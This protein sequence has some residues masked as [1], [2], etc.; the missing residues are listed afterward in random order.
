MTT[1]PIFPTLPGQ[2]WSVTRTKIT[3]TRIAAHVSGREVRSANYA[4]ALH[5]FELTFNG[6]DSESLYPGLLAQSL[7]T[8]EAFYLQ[9]QGQ[10]G[11]FVYIDPLDS[12]SLAA[13]ASFGPGD[14]VSSTFTLNRQVGAFLE[15]AS[16][17]VSLASVT[18]NGA[19]A[20][21]S[22]V[23]PNQVALG[24]TPTVGTPLAASFRYGFLCRFMDDSAEFEQFMLGLWSV[25]SLK[26]RSIR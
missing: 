23:A 14:G 4:H 9:C 21:G 19:A 3:S 6:L 24:S 5:Q 18:V 25:K 22:L 7:Q 13:N 12:N 1:P 16:Y 8:L 11:A 17:V 20:A 2:G 15:P 26:F 10:F